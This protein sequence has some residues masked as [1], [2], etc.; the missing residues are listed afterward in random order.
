MEL[1]GCDLI[2]ITE[3]LWVSSRD[4]S[5]GMNGYSSPRKDRTVWWTGQVALYVTE[6]RRCRALCLGT[7]DEPDESDAI[8]AASV[9]D[10]PARNK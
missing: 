2:G 7:G 6:Q 8:V 5:A 4:Q 10:L 1:Q 9:T 3:M